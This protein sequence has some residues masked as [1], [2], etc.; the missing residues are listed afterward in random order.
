MGLASST[1]DSQFQPTL[2][3]KLKERMHA[4][5]LCKALFEEEAVEQV[6]LRAWTLESDK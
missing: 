3:V 5:V 6:Q 2:V 1:P 4:N